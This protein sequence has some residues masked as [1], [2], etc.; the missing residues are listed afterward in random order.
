MI[1]K[2]KKLLCEKK[3]NI[4]AGKT[5]I[6]VDIQPE[7]S[8]WFSFKIHH[9]TNFLNKNYSKFN[10]I[11][12][13]YNGV[14]MGMTS[15]SDYGMWLLENGLNEEILDYITFFDKGYSFFRTCMDQSITETAIVNFVKFM[16]ANDVHDSRDMDRNMWAKYLRQYRYTD[17]KEVYELL[18]CSD[19]CVHIP[20]LM[21]FIKGYTNIVLTGGGIKEC[22]KEVE[23]AL[24]AL[25][26]PYK[27]YPKFTY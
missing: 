1:I 11:I 20:D 22:L 18:K 2:L 7:Y 19:D 5:F 10:D 23:I 21:D 4:S 14:E 26:K 3:E 24:Q 8:K 16:Y 13:L 27:I 17:K 25:N 6:S 15:E 12:L 9:F